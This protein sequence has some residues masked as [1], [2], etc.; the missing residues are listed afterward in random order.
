[1]SRAAT[2]RPTL[3][4]IA[5]VRKALPIRALLIDRSQLPGDVSWKTAVARTKLR[6]GTTPENQIAADLGGSAPHSR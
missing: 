5:E 4:V 3:Q 2:L 1:M 6:R